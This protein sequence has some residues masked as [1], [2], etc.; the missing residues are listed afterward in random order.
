M[1]LVAVLLLVSVGLLAACGGGND[2]KAAAPAKPTVTP[3]P[4][5]DRADLE[6][7]RRLG[8]TTVLVRTGYG[9]RDE[10]VAPADHVVDDLAA[11]ADLILCLHVQP[12]V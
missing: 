6:P 12:A 7:G 8:L 10:A 4:S 9:R 2:E 11:A 5:I 3:F 1:R